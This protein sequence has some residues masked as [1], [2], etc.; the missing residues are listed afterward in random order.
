MHGD[1]YSSSGSASSLEWLEGQLAEKY[2]IKTQ[3]IGRSPEYSTEGQIL[4]RVPRAIRSGYELEGDPRHAEL[5]V[6][7]WEFETGR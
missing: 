7:Q 4:N 6:E 5:F 1:D 3:R 2:E